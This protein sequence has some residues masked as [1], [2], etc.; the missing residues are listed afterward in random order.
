MER[1]RGS[2]PGQRGTDWSASPQTPRPEPRP[3]AR[4]LSAR[5]VEAA[6]RGQPEGK[7]QPGEGRGGSRAFCASVGR[8]APRPDSRVHPA[9]RAG[10]PQRAEVS[11]NPEP[12]RPGPRPPHARNTVHSPRAARQLSPAPGQ[13][14]GRTTET[15]PPPVQ[16]WGWGRGRR[17]RGSAQQSGSRATEADPPPTSPPARLSSW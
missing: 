17:G 13:D 3:T 16:P 15:L 4:A 12:P 11:G 6:A 14:A 7:G 9:P 10:R 2:A 8:K 1:E 5:A